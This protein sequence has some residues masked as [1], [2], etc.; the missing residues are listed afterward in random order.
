M[1]VDRGKTMNIM[2]RLKLSVKMLFAPI[3]VL[4]FLILMAVVSY[5]GIMNQKFALDE[6]FNKRFIGYQHSAE[7]TENITSVHATL[8]KTITWMSANFDPKKVEELANAQRSIISSNIVMIEKSIKDEGLMEEERKLYT[9]SLSQIKEYETAAIGVI[10]MVAVDVNAATM[11]ISTAEE[12]YEQLNTTFKALMALEKKLSQEKFTSSQR[13]A[14]R[15]VVIFV[16]VLAA[17]IVLS[18][19]VS[20]IVARMVT[21]PILETISVIS[22]VAEGDLTRD[23]KIRSKD[24]IGQLAAAVNAMRVKVGD[25]V[26]QA[27][28]VSR[29]LS[30]SASAQA[31]SIEETSASVDELSSMTKHNAESTNAADKLMSDASRAAGEANNYMKELTASIKEI[32]LASEQTKKIIKNIDEIAFQTNLLALNAAVEAARAGEAGA[33]FAVVADEVRNLAMRATSSA[34][35]TSVLIDDIAKKVTRGAELVVVTDESFT[36]VSDSAMKV[37]ELMREIAAASREQSQGIDQINKAIAEMSNET[38]QNA[39]ISE[40][41][42]AAMSMFKTEQQDTQQHQ[43]NRRMEV[44]GGKPRKAI[45]YDSSPRKGGYALE[46]N[47][48][49]PNPESA[50]ERNLF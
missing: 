49:H 18:I 47:G 28:S 32:S 35:D 34:K 46:H 25:A 3:V 30:D 48:N 39:A 10:E 20:L 38:Q 22:E 19:L 2:G 29:Q 16:V 7:I 5:F 50:A 41:L 15:V 24:E 37:S 26:G 43:R 8:Y 31:S 42:T 13:G 33:G 9:K 23:I 12:K 4:L 11:F 27:M 14:D 17:A 44:G 1:N 45:G 21:R 36:Q 6:I 40:E